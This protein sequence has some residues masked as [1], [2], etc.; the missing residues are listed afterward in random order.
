MMRVAPSCYAYILGLQD[1]ILIELYLQ[2]NDEA[3]LNMVRIG[4]KLST[5]GGARDSWY[6]K[7]CQGL[8]HSWSAFLAIN[9]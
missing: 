6:C 3:T 9:T 4:S 1:L 2:M 7:I 8:K 5:L